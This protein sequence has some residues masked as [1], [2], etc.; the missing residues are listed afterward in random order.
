VN[1]SY[2]AEKRLQR[3]DRLRY[4]LDEFSILVV[5]VGSILLSEP[6]AQWA[7]DG[8][9]QFR[10]LYWNWWNVLFGTV[11]ALSLYGRLHTKWR[12][13]DKAKPPWG[14]RV[15]TAIAYGVSWKTM[16]GWGLDAASARGL[17]Q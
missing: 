10:Y 7:R 6:M 11:A 12:F 17:P 4:Y 13:N 8:R 3:I 16:T 14:T 5:L 9:V 15:S 1:L 2:S